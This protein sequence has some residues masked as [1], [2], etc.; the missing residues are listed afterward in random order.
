MRL[1]PP[2][3]HNRT[4]QRLLASTPHRR[5]G[6]K[7]RK[8]C[9]TRTRLLSACCCARW[10]GG[11]E[12]VSGRRAACVAGDRPYIFCCCCFWHL[13]RHFVCNHHRPSKMM[14]SVW[15]HQVCAR[16]ICWLGF[17]APVIVLACR[18]HGP[19][20]RMHAAA[21]AFWHHHQQQS[22]VQSRKESF[23][24]APL[25]SGHNKDRCR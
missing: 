21:A 10:G 3:L 1:R 25:G 2:S 4:S 6:R 24:P 7:R 8:T 16:A 20:M 14:M 18:R 9:T 5:P 11:L 22:S 17:G 15:L 23:L 19:L 12:L 13:P